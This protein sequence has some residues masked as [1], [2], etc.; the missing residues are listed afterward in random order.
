[1]SEEMTDVER[2]TAALAE[3]ERKRKA[4]VESRAADDN[5]RRAVA[6]K[7]HS[8]GDAKARQVLDRLN[9]AAVRFDSELR[10][11]E[12]A[13]A[14]GQGRLQ[15]ARAAEAQAA[16]RA[17]A[18]ELKK[19][20]EGMSEHF[21]VVDDALADFVTAS[22]FL[23]ADFDHLLRLGI[24]SPRQEQLDVLGY[25]ALLTSLGQAIPWR[26]RFQV[27]AP[28]ERKTFASLGTAWCEHLMRDVERRLG[29]SEPAKA[30]EE[31]AA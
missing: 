27:L 12:D 10:S 17:A 2:A 1:M 15:Q 30:T 3:L 23:K 16:D 26:R 19:L 18:L 21:A 20:V 13:I 6:F 29:E 22:N 14:E 7:A 24:P 5:E 4:L 9:A 8:D 31:A 11:V 25:A 28:R